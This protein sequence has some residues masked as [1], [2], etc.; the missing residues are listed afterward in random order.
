MY[1]YFAQN[2]LIYKPLLCF[3]SFCCPLLT[4]SRI[5]TYICVFLLDSFACFVWFKFST[6]YHQ[7]P[8][9]KR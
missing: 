5:V 7:S 2:Q 1:A 4:Y 9:T 8:T 3:A 6:T